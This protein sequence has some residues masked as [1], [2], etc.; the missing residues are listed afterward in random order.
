MVRCSSRSRRRTLG[1]VVCLYPHLR[2]MNESHRLPVRFYFALP[3]LLALLRGGDRR[4]AEMNATEA[5]VAGIA[6]YIISYFYF[7]G[8]VPETIGWELRGLILA[9]LAF[10]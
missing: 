6:I 4:R 7:A 8:F 10:A 1:P 2:P 9:G 5:W 3:R